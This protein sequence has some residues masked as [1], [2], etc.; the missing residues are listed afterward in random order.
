MK[1]TAAVI[2][3]FGICFTNVAA[4]EGTT[5]WVVK[6]SFEEKYLGLN[7]DNLSG[8][9]LEYAESK[10]TKEELRHAIGFKIRQTKKRLLEASDSNKELK[11][12]RA[13]KFNLWQTNGDL[14]HKHIINVETSKIDENKEKAQLKEA[15]IKIMISKYGWLQEVERY[16]EVIKEQ[17]N[18]VNKKNNGGDQ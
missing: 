12:W 5:S 1:R 14:I 11:A 9:Y 18:G 16:K 8:M 6:E 3:L 4:A 10:I 15:A 17:K 13:R 7:E 2:L